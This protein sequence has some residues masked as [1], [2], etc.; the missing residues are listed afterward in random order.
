MYETQ[1]GLL[2]S[3]S[4][5][6][7]CYQAA[8][9][10]CVHQQV[11]YESLHHIITVHVCVNN[12][13]THHTTNSVTN[14]IPRHPS[15]THHARKPNSR[16]Y[17]RLTMVWEAGVL[18]S[19]AMV[20]AVCERAMSMASGRTRPAGWA[21]WSNTTSRGAQ[22]KVLEVHRLKDTCIKCVPFLTHCC[23]SDML[24]PVQISTL[25]N[26]A[27]R[28][29]FS[30]ELYNRINKTKMKQTFPPNVYIIHD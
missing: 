28:F 2:I 5:C 25:V 7:C 29:F 26:V 12:N 21:T 13:N 4:C 24:W 30:L 9:R 3:H 23:L 20:P 16:V 10:I 14:V 18:S 6:H 17:E 11:L 8:Y 15:T 1:L 19:R 22:Q 27:P